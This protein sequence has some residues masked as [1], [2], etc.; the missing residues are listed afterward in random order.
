MRADILLPRAHPAEPLDAAQPAWSR[1]EFEAQLRERGRSYP[2]HHPFY[3]L[4]NGG[5]ATPE[6]VRGWVANRSYYQIAIPIKD[7]RDPVELPRRPGAARLGA[8]H[9]RPR[10]LRAGGRA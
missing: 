7:R 5:G 3:V 10:R 9:P 2:I 4:L 6:Q 8:A 1:A